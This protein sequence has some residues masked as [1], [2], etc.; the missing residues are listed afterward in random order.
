MNIAI[1]GGGISGM[2]T[3]NLLSQDHQVTLYEA[4]H[5]LGGHTDTHDV[6]SGED[7]YRVDTGFIVFNE[8]TYPNFIRMLDR[9]GV[10]SQ[11][12]VMSFSVSCKQTGLEYSATNLATL[13]SQHRNLLNLPF[14]SM[15][16][17]IFRFNLESKE[18]LD[19]EDMSLS[20]ADYLN[21]RG[22]SQMFKDKFL[23]PMGSAIWSAD[24]DQFREF[25]AAAFAHFFANHGLLNI[26]DQPQWRVV[27]GGSQQY[28]EPLSKPFRDG[29]RLSTPVSRVRRLADRVELTMPDGS[30]EKHDQVVLAC[31]SDQALAM[32]ADPS[33]AER[34]LLGAIP[35]QP[36][37]TLLHTD[38]GMMPQLKK[39]WASWNYRIPETEREGV[40]V[41]Y[42]MNR[43]QSLQAEVDFCVSLNSP[44]DIDPSR[45]IKSIMYHHPVYSARA[46]LA[47]KR[48]DEISGVNR[49]WYCGAYWGYG[50]HEDGVKSALDVCAHFGRSL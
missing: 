11:P 36:N 26:F 17:D 45:I 19:H 24:P 30:V 44:S 27:C 33:D 25:P 22:Y 23:I 48:R 8:R 3:A 13:F 37:L 46:F 28:V 21:K 16:L 7:N 32:L 10:A 43:L 1:I 15:L 40:A 12:S 4:N 50:F 18:L 31:H 2:L 35:Y 47:Q 9:L 29:V 41:T 14:W 38:S 6:R 20:I 34:E 42:W 5:Y 39:A 49:T